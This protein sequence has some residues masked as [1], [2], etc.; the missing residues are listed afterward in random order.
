[1][2]ESVAGQ[3]AADLFFLVIYILCLMS[4]ARGGFNPFIYF[5]F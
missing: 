3:I 5:Q 4:L 2:R 1:M